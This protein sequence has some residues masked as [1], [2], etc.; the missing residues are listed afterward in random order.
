MIIRFMRPNEQHKMPV[1][2]IEYKDTKQ[3]IGVWT[4]FKNWEKN[5]PIVAIDGHGRIVG[6]HAATFNKKVYVNSY[7][8]FVSSKARGKGLGGNM[9]FRVL[10]EASKRGLTR[11]KAAARVDGDGDRFYKG[12]GMEPISYDKD[13]NYYDV[14]ISSDLNSDNDWTNSSP[15]PPKER[16]RHIKLGRKL[17]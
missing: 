15:M 4:R 11:F 12:F 1:E 9:F 2:H 10:L 8:Q 17:Y 16:L 6:F 14:G 5:P 13:H 3:F 7:Y